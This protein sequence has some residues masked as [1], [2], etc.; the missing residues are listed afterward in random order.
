MT[1]SVLINGAPVGEGALAFTGDKL[2]TGKDGR[3]VL[4]IG[5]VAMLIDPETEVEF[6]AT[7]ERSLAVEVLTVLTGKMLSV[8]GKGAKEIRTP[9]ATIG[10]RGTAAYVDAGPRR[11]YACVCYGTADLQVNDAPEARETVKTK[12]HE[13]PR[14]LYP[15]GSKVLIEKAPVIDHTDKELIMLEALVERVPPFGDKP[16]DNY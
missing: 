9:V 1:G 11:T 10:I 7:E 14:F 13:N 8:F 6:G 5:G 15:K 3:A 12:H 16:I 2:Q 4:V